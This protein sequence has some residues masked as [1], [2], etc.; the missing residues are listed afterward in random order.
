MQPFVLAHPSRSAQAAMPASAIAPMERVVRA[1]LQERGLNFWVSGDETTLPGIT[2]CW[3]TI[4]Y[5][6]PVQTQ[7]QLNPPQFT[8]DYN[9]DEKLE[10]SNNDDTS[11]AD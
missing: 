7:I 4:H 6:T 5:Q 1:F 9:D 2:G 10:H 8:Q 3:E 11:P